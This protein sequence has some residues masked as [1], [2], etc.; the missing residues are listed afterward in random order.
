MHPLSHTKRL[1]SVEKWTIVRPCLSG[2]KDQE[3]RYRKRFLDLIM[4]PE[5]SEIFKAGWYTLT[6]G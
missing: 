1:C 4:N 5:V 6:P 2:L 3:T